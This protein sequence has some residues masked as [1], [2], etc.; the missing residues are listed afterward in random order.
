VDTVEV[1]GIVD[2]GFYQ[3]FS[4]T[5]SRSRATQPGGPS[6]VLIENIVFLLDI[7]LQERKY[8]NGRRKSSSV[9]VGKE[10]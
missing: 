9:I 3:Y 10:S 7:S 6:G 5:F 1:I 2:I 8:K 4:S